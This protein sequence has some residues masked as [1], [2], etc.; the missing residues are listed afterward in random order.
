MVLL[1]TA[2]IDPSQNTTVDS[3]AAAAVAVQVVSSLVTSLQ[4]GLTASGESLV[5]RWSLRCVGWFLL[6]SMLLQQ[7]TRVKH[8]E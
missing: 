6:V 8:A 4:D 7:S 5:G 2:P 1:R 3:G